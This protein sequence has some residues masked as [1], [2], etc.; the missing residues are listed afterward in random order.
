M[1][2]DVLQPLTAT[3]H[4]GALCS[5]V[6]AGLSSVVVVPSLVVLAGCLACY[7]EATCYFWPA[8]T[9]IHRVIDEGR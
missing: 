4:Q 3:W 1:P 8:D 6:L 7:A 5:V 9:Q 2:L